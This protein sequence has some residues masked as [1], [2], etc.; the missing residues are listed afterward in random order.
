MSVGDRDGDEGL[1]DPIVVSEVVDP[2]LDMVVDPSV[3]DTSVLVVESVLV[4]PTDPVSV[5]VD[6]VDVY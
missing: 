6:P 4:D 2:E 3:D 5:F 1:D